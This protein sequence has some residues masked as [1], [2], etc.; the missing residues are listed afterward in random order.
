MFREYAIT[1]PFLQFVAPAD[2]PVD[3]L[4][5]VRLCVAQGGDVGEHL[6]RAGAA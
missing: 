6:R 2:K 3:M 1:G 4:I 5:V